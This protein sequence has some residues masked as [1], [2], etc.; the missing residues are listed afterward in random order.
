MSRVCWNLHIPSPTWK[1][2]WQELDHF[3]S[4]GHLGSD[5]TISR[6]SSDYPATLKQALLRKTECSGIF[7]NGSFIHS[8]ARSLR[9]LFS[10]I[11]CENWFELL[12]VNLTM[13]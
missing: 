8:S 2:S 9:G 11:Y 13:F 1:T 4:P 6:L 5:N 7:Q 10:D 12:G 3:T